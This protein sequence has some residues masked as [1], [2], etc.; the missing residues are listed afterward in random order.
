[1]PQYGLEGVQEQAWF[2]GEADLLGT[3]QMIEC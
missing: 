1:M 2:G 3:V